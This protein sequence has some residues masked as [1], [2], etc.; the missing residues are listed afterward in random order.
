M[1]KTHRLRHILAG[2]AF[3]LLV[4]VSATPAIAQQPHGA[5][6]SA[7]AGF[8]TAMHAA[9]TKMMKDME[10]GP[11][12]GDP[13]RDFMAMM[14]PHHQG[15]IDM[16]RLVLLHGR[17]PLVRKLAAEIIAAQQT[18]IAT[19]RNRLE[20]LRAGPDPNPGGYPALE[21]T[22]GPAAGTTPSKP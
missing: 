14:I 17:D 9:M 12:T 16:A 8:E 5:G 19:M 3:C 15:A 10:S 6:H 13:D 7:N 21:G 1:R 2:A 22:R 11:M 18:E 4:G 20:I